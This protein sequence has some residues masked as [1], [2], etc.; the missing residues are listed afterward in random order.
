MT[1]RILFAFLTWGLMS[2]PVYPS[3]LTAA[4]S[5]TSPELLQSAFGTL[6]EVLESDTTTR[7]IHAAEVL[8]E[9]GHT[10]QVYGW[11]HQS[12]EELDDLPIRRV[13]VWRALAGS[14]PSE[15][16]RS[17]WVSKIVAIA[18]TVEAPDRLHAVE[19][20]AKLRVSPQ[21]ELAASL[22][23]WKKSALER[24]VVFIQWALWADAP[25]ANLG[26][27]L[28]TYLNSADEI[29]QLRAAYITRWLGAPPPASM[30][31]VDLANRTKGSDQV[32]AIVLASAYLLGPKLTDAPHWRSQMES[33][34]QGADPAATYHALQ[35]LMPFYTNRDL[36][37]ISPLLQHSDADVRVA[38]AWTILTIYRNAQRD[39]KA[40]SSSCDL[41]PT[42]GG[43]LPN[44]R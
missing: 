33:L 40:A 29:T 20:L 36:D 8:I 39:S 13:T 43:S 17:E 14:A 38:A 16:E 34:A 22:Q 12:D 37:R 3:T 25:T 19:S 4:Q 32:A 6:T 30:A 11:F 31:L 7:Q 5:E 28:S 41:K 15:S 1:H 23:E 10:T 9:F 27:I 21:L 44:G 26:E 42:G 2:S 24:E 18:S 35:G